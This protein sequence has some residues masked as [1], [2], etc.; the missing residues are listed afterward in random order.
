MDKYSFRT[1]IMSFRQ[2]HHEDLEF[3]TEDAAGSVG[4]VTEMVVSTKH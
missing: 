1:G 3:T 2:R 4:V